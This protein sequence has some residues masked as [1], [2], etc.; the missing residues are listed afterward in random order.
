MKKI[1]ILIAFAYISILYLGQ[2][3]PKDK[4]NMDQIDLWIKVSKAHTS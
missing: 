1:L 3:F 2:S 4:L